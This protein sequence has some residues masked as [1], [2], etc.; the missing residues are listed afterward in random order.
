M[1]EPTALLAIEASQ[2]EQ[3]VAVRCGD[4]STL[5]ESV[6]TGD[7]SQED[8]VPAIDRAM[9]R[10][11]LRPADLRGV[12]LNAGP[13]GFTGL[14][15]A[16]AAAQAV[17]IATGA[18]VVQ[19]CA[20]RCARQASVM[21]GELGA[22][23]RAWVALASKGA[24][25]WLRCVGRHEVDSE[26]PGRSMQAEAWQV[27]GARHLICDEHLPRAF[28]ARA[29]AHGLHT[30]SLRVDAR[31]VL[32]AGLADLA[33]GR[34]TPPEALVPAYPREAEAVRLWRSRHGARTDGTG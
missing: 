27:E 34:R 11:G 24:E 32:E 3:S 14:R 23:E 2:R 4:G 25:S 30:L 21:A 8:L 1:P 7:R 17:A 5:V 15:V 12:L 13:G 10:A 6:R 33:D 9:T 18:A 19:V 20:A 31:A 29:K 28:A 26:A 16:H 22:D